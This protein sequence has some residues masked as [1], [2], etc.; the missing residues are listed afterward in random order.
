MPGGHSDAYEQVKP[1]LERIAAKDKD[2]ETTVN[3]LLD[4]LAQ[5]LDEVEKVDPF[6][7]HQLKQLYHEKIFLRLLPLNFHSHE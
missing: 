2:D 1:F 5:R 3:N 4:A 6:L 7:A